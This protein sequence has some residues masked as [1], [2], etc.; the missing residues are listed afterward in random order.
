MHETLNCNNGFGLTHFMHGNKCCRRL[1]IVVD[2]IPGIDLIMDTTFNNSD[3]SIKHTFDVAK[4][5]F[6]R[7][8]RRYKMSPEHGLIRLFVVKAMPSRNA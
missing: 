2:L 5:Q 1:L 8:Q 4:K 6:R 7:L 3:W